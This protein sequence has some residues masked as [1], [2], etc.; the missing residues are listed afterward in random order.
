MLLGAI[1]WLTNWCHKSQHKQF[2]FIY[3]LNYSSCP[4]QS[5]VLKFESSDIKLACEAVTL[6][7]DDI[8]DDSLSNLEKEFTFTNW[9]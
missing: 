7:K 6:D 9:V 8:S 4:M 5:L 1:N 3:C 2:R